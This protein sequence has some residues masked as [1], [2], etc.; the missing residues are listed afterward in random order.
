MKQE[1]ETTTTQIT[2]HVISVWF[3][4]TKVTRWA[5]SPARVSSRRLFQLT[6]GLLTT[7]SPESP[8]KKELLNEEILVIILKYG[9]FLVNSLLRHHCT[10][11]SPTPVSIEFNI[12]LNL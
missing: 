9:S 10:S 1:E 2:R 4:V 8:T 12:S 3:T 11:M 6:T 7:I 5:L